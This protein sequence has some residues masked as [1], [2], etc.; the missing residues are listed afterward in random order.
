[1]TAQ[2]VHATA[3]AFGP[4][5]GVLIEGPSGSGKSGLA[6]ALVAAGAELVADDRAVLFAAGGV[7]FARA[8]R[9]IRGLIEA[10][11]LGL[12]RL[13]SRALARIGLIVA[14]DPS[15]PVPAARAR[16]PE[17]EA[18]A[19]LGCTVPRLRGPAGPAGAAAVPGFALAL[20]LALRAGPARPG[21]LAA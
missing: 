15:D 6:L 1:M 16:L 12:L 13:P 11:G 21:P 2:P 7:L 14:L 4:D 8:P 17:A 18:A 3:V 20:A 9:A 5:R 10:R 19:R